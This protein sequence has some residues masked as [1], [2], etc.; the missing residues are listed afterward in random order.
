MKRSV[1][2][3][4]ARAKRKAER[5]ASQHR[6]GS[7]SNYARKREFLMR[8]TS[9]DEGLGRR[10]AKEGGFNYVAERRLFGF[11]FDGIK[12]WRAA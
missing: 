6:H 5:Q 3:A 10:L 12:P 9:Q 1:K 4:K 7:T 11:D 8:A 2:R